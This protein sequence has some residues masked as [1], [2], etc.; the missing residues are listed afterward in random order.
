MSWG[1]L[2]HIQD[3]FSLNQV[4]IGFCFLFGPVCGLEMVFYHSNSLYVVCLFCLRVLWIPRLGLSY[5]IWDFLRQ[6]VSVGLS[7]HL[8]FSWEINNTW[9][10]LEYRFPCF[11][12]SCNSSLVFAFSLAPSSQRQSGGEIAGSQGFQQLFSCAFSLGLQACPQFPCF[13][14]G[15]VGIAPWLF[16]PQQ[17]RGH[18]YLC[19]VLQRDPLSRVRPSFLLCSR[20]NFSRGVPQGDEPRLEV[21]FVI[22]AW[23]ERGVSCLSSLCGPLGSLWK[24]WF[25]FWRRLIWSS[26]SPPL[27]QKWQDSLLGLGFLFQ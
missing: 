5:H 10:S 16:P 11:P 6:L 27:L 18:F 26:K 23:E 2:Q 1:Q 13:P 3:F 12:L 20:F 9:F 14:Y 19:R 8:Q 22:G 4:F 25:F 15:K 21:S 7:E 17:G 24:C